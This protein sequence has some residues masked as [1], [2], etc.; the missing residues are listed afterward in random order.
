MTEKPIIIEYAQ[1]WR[2][3]Q[4]G[5]ATVQLVRG[6]TISPC[7]LWNGKLQQWWNIPIAP[8][9]DGMAERIY[10]HMLAEEERVCRSWT[11]YA[12]ERETP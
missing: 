5:I 4:G 10:E 3:P 9:Y 6:E 2:Y 7:R 8:A 11:R 12:K 1:A